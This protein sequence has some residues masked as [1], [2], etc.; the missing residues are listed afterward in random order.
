MR[1]YLVESDE[2]SAFVAATSYSDAIEC[3]KKAQVVAEED[4]DRVN[5]FLLIDDPHS[6]VF[7]ADEDEFIL[8]V[9]TCLEIK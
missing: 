9:E 3:W 7:V 4:D 5:E 1:L 2:F 8:P 6:V